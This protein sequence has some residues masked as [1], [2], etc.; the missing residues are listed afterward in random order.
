MNPRP[1]YQ[2]QIGQW[3][4]NAEARRDAKKRLCA[5]MLPKADGGGTFEVAGINDR[6]DYHMACHLRNLIQLGQQAQAEIDAR[7]YILR[8]TDIVQ[9]WSS[10]KAIE[11]YLRDC[12]F[13]RGP[14]G[15]AKILQIALSHEHADIKVDG[16]VGPITLG[17]A[18]QIKSARE[19]LP[20]LRDAREAYERH[21]APP[22]G[23]RKQFWD[24][25]VNR[26]NNSLAFAKTLL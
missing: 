9:P 22:V 7:D 20:L 21:I 18:L 23:D 13:N 6:Y 10:S 26:W 17:Y 14:G 5:Y 8:Y 2:L 16:H 4:V 11:A 1:F 12:C 25:L 19:F 15:A 3:I 24:G